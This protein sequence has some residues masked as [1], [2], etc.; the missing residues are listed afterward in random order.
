MIESDQCQGGP[1]HSS[2]RTR[3]VAK[4]NFLP[5]GLIKHNLPRPKGLVEVAT[6]LEVGPGIRPFNWYTPEEYVYFEPYEV[7]HQKMRAAGYR[8]A[9][10]GADALVQY[11]DDSFD[12]IYALDVIEHMHGRAGFKFIQE[13]LRVA[14]RQVVFYTPLGFMEQHGDAWGLDGDYWQ[15]HRSGWYP[16]DFPGWETEKHAKSFFAVFTK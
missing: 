15:E 14:S 16:S 8:G 13:A 4:E 3:K 5:N 7:Y 11:G 2:G 10:V 12:A 9:N 1:A 6:V